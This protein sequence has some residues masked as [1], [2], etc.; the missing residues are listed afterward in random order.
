MRRILYIY[1]IMCIALLTACQ[2]DAGL[3]TGEA[4]L[5]L[6]LTR[7]GR[8]TATTRAVDDDLAVAIYKDHTTP[9]KQYSAG[10]IPRKISL[11]PGTFRIVAYTDNQ[12]TW[13]SAN[14][15]KGAA[16]YYGDT[17]ITMENDMVFRLRMEV[18]ATN[19]AVGLQ[20]PE[21]FNDLF[22]TYTFTL[23]SGTRTTTIKEGERAFFDV[24]DGGFSYALRATN[25]DGKTSSHS[26]I[27]FPD[28]AAG[29][30]FTIHY[31]YD[32]DATSGG[33][34]IVITDDMGNDDTDISL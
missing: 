27:E 15:G 22:R 30:L 11:E 9:Y 34:D 13:P 10:S 8:P 23:K 5:E 12:S 21:H 7:A 31:S 25:T 16:C 33:V 14:D 19:Y 32:S 6:E 17:I 3:P 1:I 18:P 4:V 28:I 29:K 24:A 2:Q 20:L 26:D